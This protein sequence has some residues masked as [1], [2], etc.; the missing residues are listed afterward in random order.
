[1]I[2]KVIL[3]G[4]LGKDPELRHT[5]A[6]K[7][8]VDFTLATTSGF[9]DKARTDWHNVTAWEKTADAV[10]AYLKKGSKVYVEGRIEYQTSEKDGVKRY[11]T[12]I[13]AQDVRFLDSKKDGEAPED[14]F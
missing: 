10:A 1:M 2:N 12:K 11:F 8:V 3:V 9:G 14:P 6:G 13:I 5:P 7:S 4:N